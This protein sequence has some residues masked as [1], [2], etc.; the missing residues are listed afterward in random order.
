M[1]AQ[2]FLPGRLDVRAFATA[3]ASIHGE[4]PVAQLSRLSLSL[5][6]QATDQPPPAVTWS[7]TGEARKRQVGGPEPWIHLQASVVAPLTCQRC[8]QRADEPLDVDRWF[9]FV[10]SEELAAEL[11][12][13]SDDDVLVES[14]VFDLL[15][16]IEDELL[17]TMP[18]V[19]MHDQC[20]AAPRHAQASV[21]HL[22]ADPVAPKRQPFAA[23]AALKTGRL[24]KEEGDD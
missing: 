11:D 6:T 23:L 8:L 10:G 9:R 19:P 12:E 22:D 18:M 16:L 5:H 1:T 7:A 14:R 15:A 13:Q 3:G 4:L 21:A 17:L 20:P 24:P 2:K